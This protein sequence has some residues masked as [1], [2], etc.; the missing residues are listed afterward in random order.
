MLDDRIVENK[1]RLKPDTT[2]AIATSAL[3]LS[4]GGLGVAVESDE[5]D[6]AIGSTHGIAPFIAENIAPV[7]SVRTRWGGAP[8]RDTGMHIFD[9]GSV[10]RLQRDGDEFLFELSSPSFG[11]APYKT[12]RVNSSFTAADVKLRRHYVGDR[13]AIYPLEYP[14]DEL[15]FIHLLAQGRGVELH[16]CGIV[17]ASGEAYLFVG[18]S[19]AGKSTTARLWARKHDVTILSDDRII[20]R[21]IDGALLA[22]GTPWHGDEPF[23][24]TGP[25]PLARIF[26]LRHAH[27]NQLRDLSP[28]ETAARLFAAS[29]VP[30]YD[31]NAVEFTL[32]FLETIARRV[33][34]H[35]LY[36]APDRSAVDF[37]RQI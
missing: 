1:V 7:L 19:G 31:V 9:S 4:I 10:W 36:F 37:I 35:E 2:H 24:A 6:L 33:S 3:R 14:L 12:A 28:A 23:A 34:C 29:F 15:L 18:Q 13:V 11:T 32:A 27:S 30:V 17:D 25:A 22:Y 21:D 5:P 16:A 8:E 26:F 20:V